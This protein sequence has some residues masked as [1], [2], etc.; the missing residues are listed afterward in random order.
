MGKK[1]IYEVKLTWC[2][3]DVKKNNLCHERALL[4]KKKK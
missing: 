4:Q 2:V 1:I 3:K